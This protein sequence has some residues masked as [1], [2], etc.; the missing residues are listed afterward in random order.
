MPA[1]RLVTIDG[2]ARGV[3]DEYAPKGAPWQS[4]AQHYDFPPG[5]HTIKIT[6]LDEKH[7][8]SRD[9]WI[10]VGNLRFRIVMPDRSLMPQK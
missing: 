9:H 10:T 3:I 5:K 7:P 1:R 8:N 6:V 4:G 2:K